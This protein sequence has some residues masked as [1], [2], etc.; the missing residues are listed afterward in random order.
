MKKTLQT[1]GFPA[2]WPEGWVALIGGEQQFPPPAKSWTP[3]WLVAWSAATHYENKPGTCCLAVVKP[4]IGPE[5]F[6]ERKWIQVTG[7]NQPRF[8]EKKCPNK[9]V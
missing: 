5:H 4:I 9:E 8:G 6:K 3:Q 1:R 7:G 2:W